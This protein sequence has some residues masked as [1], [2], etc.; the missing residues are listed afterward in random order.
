[1]TN[2]ST[3]ARLKLLSQ[4]IELIEGGDRADSDPMPDISVH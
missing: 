4:L 2:A 1:M 3:S